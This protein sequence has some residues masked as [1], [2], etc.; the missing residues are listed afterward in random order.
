MPFDNKMLATL[1]A[2]GGTGGSGGS[3]SGSGGGEYFDNGIIKQSALPEGYPYSS[4]VTMVE[5]LP[6]I[7]PELRGNYSGM[8]MYEAALDSPLT[9]VT[10][11]EYTVIIDGKEALAKAHEFNAMTVLGNLSIASGTLPNTEED[12]LII[13][14]ETA[15]G[16]YL[17]EDAGASHVISIVAAEEDISY[18]DNKYLALPGVLIARGDGAGAEVFNGG[19]SSQATGQSAHAE[20]F[21]TTASGSYSHAEGFRTEAGA[22]Y[23]HAEGY[24][25]VASTSGAHAEGSDTEAVGWATHAEGIETYSSGDGSHAEG[26]NTGAMG[27][28]SH[29]EGK[30]SDA[31]GEASHAEGWTSKAEGKYSHAEGSRVWATGNV[32]HAEGYET[33][34]IGQYSHAEGHTTRASSENQ[35]VQGKHNVEDTEGVYAHIV[36]N[37]NS[38]TEPSNAHTLDWSGNAWFAGYVEG[39]ALILKSSTEGSTKRFKITVND[40]G[41]IS[42]TEVTA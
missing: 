37:G 34:A 25:T 16:M 3:G 24:Q 18:L 8:S 21:M 38:S 1:R 35:H 26:N 4:G 13:P 15:L 23:S 20:G 29:A 39:T 28:Y 17:L 33:K 19:S 9:L 31:I 11:Q 30:S 10:G 14:Q 22:Q 12:F 27:N 41:T 42:A 2:M 40:S 5:V 6:P 32:S 7:T 36:G